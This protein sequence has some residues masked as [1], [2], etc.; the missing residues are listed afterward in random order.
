VNE[1]SLNLGKLSAGSARCV[2]TIVG[3]DIGMQ[4]VII[5]GVRPFS[6]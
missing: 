3:Q 1:D 6:P 5:L 2:G 4:N